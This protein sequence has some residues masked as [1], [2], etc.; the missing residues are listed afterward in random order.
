MIVKEKHRYLIL[1]SFFSFFPPMVVTENHMFVEKSQRTVADGRD[2]LLKY[3]K[4][5]L[6][7]MGIE[8]EDIRQPDLERKS[9]H[10]EKQPKK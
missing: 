6:Q 9:C 10:S 1:S 2:E 5:Q 8:D 4:V 3:P 7:C